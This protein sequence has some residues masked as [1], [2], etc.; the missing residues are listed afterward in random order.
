MLLMTNF[1]LWDG[2][3]ISDYSGFLLHNVTMISE[4]FGPGILTRPRP[5]FN[6]LQKKRGWRESQSQARHGLPKH[7]H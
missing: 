3:F 1:T 5:A 4:D 7:E 6:G 2:Q